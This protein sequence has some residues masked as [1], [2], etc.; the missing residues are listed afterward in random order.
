MQQKSFYR[1]NQR[2]SAHTVRLIGSDGTQL[3]VK[4]LNDALGIARQKGLDLIEI[5]PQANP[6][7]C[8]ILDFSKFRYEQEKKAREA[9]RKQKAGMLKEVRFRPNIGQHDL[10]TKL[11]HINEFLAQRDKVRVTVVFRGRENAHKDLGVNLLNSLTEKLA[12][13]A[14]VEGGITGERNR[15]MITFIPKH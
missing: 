11:K 15:I 5:A 6:P 13:I 9:R 10:G 2:I 12:E 7:V 1:I 4:G 3:G 14:V 8:K